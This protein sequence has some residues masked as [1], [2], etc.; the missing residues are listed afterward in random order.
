MSRYNVSFRLSDW[1]R[2]FY[3]TASPDMDQR[4]RVKDLEFLRDNFPYYANLPQ[5]NKERFVRK[6]NMFML[7]RD[8]ICRE[9]NT[10]DRE[11]KLLISATAAQ[12]TFGLPDIRIPFLKKIL[13]YPSRYFNKLT[14]RY[15]VGEINM[16]GIMVLSKEDIIKGIRN[17]NDGRNIVL[18]ELAHAL[19]IENKIKNDEFDFLCKK[20]YADFEQIADRIIQQVNQGSIP[21]MERYKN[22]LNRS[23]LFPVCVEN[24]FEKSD[25]F[26]DQCLPMYNI[27]VRI[28]N[29]DPLRFKN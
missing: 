11:I 15:H 21:F 22:K 10:L 1:Q 29:Q 16:A 26:K 12:I 19:E 3:N 13:I 25:L 14:Q 23:E 5:E 24:F 2:R 17:T 8:F 27:M 20:A 9:N 7:L 18:H 6:L 28:L 4:V